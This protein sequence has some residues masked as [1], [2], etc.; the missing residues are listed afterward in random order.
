MLLQ[1]GVFT[2]VGAQSKIPPVMHDLEQIQQ[3][4]GDRHDHHTGENPNDDLVPALDRPK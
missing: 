1:V 3:R 2:P 4:D